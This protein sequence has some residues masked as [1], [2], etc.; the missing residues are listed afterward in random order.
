MIPSRY[1]GR[2][3]LPSSACITD[4]QAPTVPPAQAQQAFGNP[5]SHTNNPALAAAYNAAF[6]ALSAPGANFPDLSQLPPG[7]VPFALGGQLG[8]P[9]P[10]GEPQARPPVQFMS[11]FPSFSVPMPA[12]GFGGPPV[13]PPNLPLHPDAAAGSSGGEANDEVRSQACWNFQA[14]TCT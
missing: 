7:S 13:P 8:N 11:P 5:Y 9:P 14:C 3:Q 1:K 4:A 2:L 12:A 10:P 6:A